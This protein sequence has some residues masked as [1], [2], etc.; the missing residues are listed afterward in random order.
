MPL[1][2]LNTIKTI[3]RALTSNHMDARR[4]SIITADADEQIDAKHSE[5]TLR[6]RLKQDDCYAGS[7]FALVFY[8]Y[9]ISLLCFRKCF[10]FFFSISDCKAFQICLELLE[11]CPSVEPGWTKV[12]NA[13]Y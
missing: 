10:F 8:F 11:N 6:N 13:F 5:E 2:Q 12:L 3:K 4:R 9:F 1:Q 7:E